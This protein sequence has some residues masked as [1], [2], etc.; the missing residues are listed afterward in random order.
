MDHVAQKPGQRNPSPPFT[1]SSL[2]QEASVKLGYSVRQ[3]M[4][5]AQ[6]LYENGHITYMR[7]DSVN[8]SNQSL[9]S[10]QKYIT[11]AYGTKYHEKRVYKTKNASAQFNRSFL[12]QAAGSKWRARAAL[13]WFFEPRLLP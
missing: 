2:Q 7:T 5:V 9:N 12:L 8:L 3:T 1:T 13:A 6:R 11:D 4:I 10:A